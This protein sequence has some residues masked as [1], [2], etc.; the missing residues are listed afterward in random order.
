MGST[1]A[2]AA[3]GALMTGAGVSDSPAQAAIAP[4]ERS[5]VIQAYRIPAGSVA[6]ALNVIADE[7]DLHVLYDARLTH[8][9]MT[10]G[11]SGKYSVREALGALLA[12]T[13]LTY[14]FSRDGQA[15]SIV[16][17]QNDAGTQT[18]ASGATPLP[19]IDIGA[20][21][22][23]RGD[24]ARARPAPGPGDR[25]TGYTAASAAAT[26][27]VD[28]PL[29]ETPISVRSVTRQTMDDQQAISVGDA[30]LTNVSGVTPL[31]NLLDVYKVRGFSV[32]QSTYKNG[33]IELRSRYLDTANLQSIDVLKGPAA[34]L[35]GRSEPGGLI[36]LVVKRPL[37]TP[38]YS[39]QEQ[40]KSYGGTR[41]TIDATGPLTADKSLLYR[42]NAEY[43]RADS[44]RDF[45]T[46][47]NFFVAPTIS[48]RP[49]EQFR[50]NV[51][52][53]YQNKTWVDD[54][55]LLPAVY[56]HPANIPISRY[57]SAPYLTTNLTNHFDKKRIAYDW[58]Y[59]ISKDWSITN[60]LSY[61]SVGTRNG[62]VAG[63]AFN[64]ITGVL[65][66]T[67]VYF[68]GNTDNTFATNLDL[69][70]K[71]ETGPL[72]HSVLLGFDYFSNY[73][74][75]K[76]Q[77][78]TPISAI[79]IYAP[80][81]Y[82][83]DLPRGGGYAHSGEQW[84][85]VYGQDMISF[86]DDSVHVLLGGRYD[87]NA[88]SSSGSYN[89][90]WWSAYTGYKTA[91]TSAFSPRVGVVYQPLPFM[92]VYG[93]FAQSFGSNNTSNYS[94][95]RPPQRGEIWE[96]GAKAE[97]LDKRLTLTM[98]YFD[99]TKTNIPTADPLN[100]T[101]SYLIGKAR[102]QGFEF[103]L[104]GRIDD[105]WSVIANYTHDDVR[106]LEGSSANALAVYNGQLASPG[107]A[108]AS[109]PRNYGNLWVK[110]DADDAFKGLSLGAGLTVTGSALGDN[111]NSFVLPGYALLN[112]MIAYTT[113]IEG[114]TVTAQLNVKNITDT[115][116]Y[117]ASQDRTYI[118]TGAPRSFLGSLRVEF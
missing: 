55:Q 27:K 114:V 112:G 36:N 78:I 111:A 16:L 34:M 20:Q 18:D 79:N 98:A 88:V 69:K 116:Y 41:T 43:Y 31:P 47:R 10:P 71:F 72:S 103:D 85:G 76:S 102:S 4:Q 37:E 50:I 91:D 22:N 48:Y 99:I 90:N 84:T 56:D 57:L 107:K 86:L 113:K 44:Y 74:G 97:L 53:E 49:I 46:D 40:V 52:F 23:G 75:M 38:Y 15:V 118:M 94:L 62:N 101:L 95:P 58:T 93:N 32:S 67:Y 26:L 7:N 17:A 66:R 59:D 96:V 24:D 63:A 73:W 64:Q 80:N 12:G 11:L 8:G 77:I 25:Y 29:L 117:P 100:S 70:G 106:T 115:V 42:V 81:Y 35:F 3:F 82:T 110:Y 105:N 65:N 87:W 51:D 92:S 33:L 2:A 60:R 83:L 39:I 89:A 28:T 30:V 13:G 6:S 14:E 1:V 54:Y 45:V 5:G 68:P 19:T 108:L 21:T 61:T 9:R 104:T 109:S